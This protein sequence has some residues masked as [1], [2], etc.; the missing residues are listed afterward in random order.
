M[1]FGMYTPLWFLDKQTV[2]DIV[3][4]TDD[5]CGK[6]LGRK[7]ELTIEIKK[8]GWF[9]TPCYGGY[10]EDNQIILLYTN[11]CF[12]IKD[13]IRCLL[14]EYTHHLQDLRE[15]DKLNEKYGYDKNPFELEAHK[16]SEYYPHVWK[17]IK[18]KI[19]KDL[20]KLSLSDISFWVCTNLGLGKIKINIPHL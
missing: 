4:L 17:R 10:D 18:N 3:R 5:W 2:T 16:V 13:L 15:Y 19:W 1:L 12:N 20:L 6:N 14:H 8:Q 11:R 7:G 9:E